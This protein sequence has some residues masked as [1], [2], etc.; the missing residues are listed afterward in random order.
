MTQTTETTNWR[1]IETAP[2]AG[3]EI[4]AWG[5]YLSAPV[6]V[7]WA[8]LTSDRGAWKASWDGEEVIES[9]TD[10]GTDYKDPGPLSHWMPLPEVPH[11]E[12]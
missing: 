7:S 9:Q 10:F 1:P 3:G 2:K 5:R 6:I 11:V 12:D 8:V 4:L